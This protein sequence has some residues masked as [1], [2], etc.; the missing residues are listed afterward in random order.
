VSNGSDDGDPVGARL[1]RIEARLGGIERLLERLE[2]LIEQA[3][4]DRR[5]RED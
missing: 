5:A 3:V 4:E 2:R 1:D